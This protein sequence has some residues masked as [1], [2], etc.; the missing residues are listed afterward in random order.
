[1]LRLFLKNNFKSECNIIYLSSK[2]MSDKPQNIVAKETKAADSDAS[3]F[4][5]K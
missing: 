3:S 5:S 2:K 4:V 1:M